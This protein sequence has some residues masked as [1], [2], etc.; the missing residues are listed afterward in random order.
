MTQPLIVL[1]NKVH[2]QPVVLGGPA[3]VLIAGPCVIESA[4][5]AH[6]MAAALKEIANHVGLPFVF[7]ASFDK[8]NRTAVD[9]FRGPG[10]DEGLEILGDIRSSLGVCVTTDV[11]TP[12]QAIRAAEVVDLLQIPAFLCRQT[13]LLVEAGRTGLPVNI[14]KG[15]FQAPWD[16]APAIE[17]VRTGGDGGVM[18]TERGASFGYNNLVVDLRS[19]VAMAQMGVP[20]CFD[21]TH[22]TQSPGSAGRH[23]GGDRRLAPVL[24]RGAVAAGVDAVFL[25]VHDNPDEALSD[26]AVQLPIDTLEPLLSSLMAFHE[27]RRLSLDDHPHC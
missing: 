20:V 5:H 12:Q 21:A 14:K 16:M 7:K 18:L 23:S 17:K 27:L 9:A 2:Q 8:A 1:K 13:D 4:S 26:A 24:A 22:A 6:K 15:Q 10:L 3:L 19:L 11:H 25:E